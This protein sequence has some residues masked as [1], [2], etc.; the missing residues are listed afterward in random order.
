MNATPETRTAACACGELSITLRG[1]PQR[2]SSCSCLECQKRTGS[3][4]GVTAFYLKEQI[5]QV[6]GKAKIFNRSSDSGRGLSMRFCPECGTTVYWELDMAPG[7]ISVAVGCFADPD[8]PA[9]KRT[10]FHSRKHHW[11]HFPPYF[12]RFDTIPD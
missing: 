11:M 12:D 5:E 2:V 6:D 9:P 3:I 8:F 4:F 10:V 1:E 7:Q